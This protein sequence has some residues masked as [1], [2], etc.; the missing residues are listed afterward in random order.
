M[1]CARDYISIRDPKGFTL[2][3]LLIAV[4]ILVIITTL[5]YGSFARSYD[6]REFVLQ[7]HER[8]HTARL[9][10]HRM[11]N[12]ISM[13]FIFDCREQNTPTGEL[14]VRT[15]FKL[16]HEGDVDRLMFASFS[17]LRMYRDVHESDQ[18][19]VTYF[20]ENDPQDSSKTNL[21]RK[22]KTHLDGKPEDGGKALL[23]CPDIEELGFELWDDSK[24][25]WEDEWDCSQVERLNQIPILVRIKLVVVDEYGKEM[26]FTTTT[27]IFTNKPLSNWMKPSQ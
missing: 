11:A 18:N 9:A 10:L 14:A 17:H 26:P 25:E 16:E 27:R 5:V 23:L 1:R 12:E 13:A 8:F 15:P 2:V 19:I 20:G 24:Q 6:A 3:E 21:M 4:A 22:I 7:A